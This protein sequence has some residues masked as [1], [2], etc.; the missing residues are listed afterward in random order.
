MSLAKIKETSGSAV[1]S[2]SC[3]DDRT[4][5]YAVERCMVGAMCEEPPEAPLAGSA[6]GGLTATL[7]SWWVADPSD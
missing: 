4:S 3:R 1:L 6:A 5:H 2:A 7:Y